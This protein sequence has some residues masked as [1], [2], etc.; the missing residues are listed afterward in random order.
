MA[1]SNG[2]DVR[3]ID[4]FE[5]VDNSN[6]KNN[7]YKIAVFEKEP[8]LNK[9]KTNYDFV[10]Y[11][12]NRNVIGKKYSNGDLEIFPEYK[13]KIKKI[14]GVDLD[15]KKII[16]KD[17]DSSNTRNMEREEQERKLEN[18]RRIEEQNRQLKKEKDEEKNK[19]QSN[20]VPVGHMENDNSE[21]K[22][23]SSSTKITHQDLINNPK[24]KDVTSWTRI[25]D[26]TFTDA[27]NPT[28]KDGTQIDK[29][30]IIV[31]EIGGDFKVLAKAMGTDEIIDLSKD[32]RENNTVKG[33]TNRIQGNVENDTGRHCTMQIPMFNNKEIVINQTPSGRIDLQQI[34]YS[35]GNDDKALPIGTDYMHPT[36]EELN[37]AKQEQE[38]IV[39]NDVIMTR[40]EI[41]ANLAGE[42]EFVYN[43]VMDK[44][45]GTSENPTNERFNEILD[46]AHEEDQE[47]NLNNDDNV[48]SL[49]NDALERRERRFR[50]PQ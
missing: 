12:Q 45:N 13:E 36:E 49:D 27:V 17:D 44:V 18:T 47:K 4:E 11:D 30:S 2:K 9:T 33:Q 14:E 34:D 50:K 15:S 22:V 21:I 10:L 40:E 3:K 26:Q 39:Y 25:D 32:A 42:N 38:G 41:E 1:Y 8:V 7:V 16:I 6:N 28:T 23:S 24:Y 20:N 35:S 46:E 19:I 31:A 29:N 48:K 43:Y 5:L 37:R